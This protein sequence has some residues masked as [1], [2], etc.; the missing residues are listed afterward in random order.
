[1]DKPRYP[2]VL[3][4]IKNQNSGAFGRG[5]KLYIRFKGEMGLDRSGDRER[6]SW[7]LNNMDCSNGFSASGSRDCPHWNIDDMSM[8]FPNIQLALAALGRVLALYGIKS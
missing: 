5:K 2:I 1:M 8:W 7:A 6:I 4:C 3:V